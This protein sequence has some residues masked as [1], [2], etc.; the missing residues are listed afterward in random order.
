[1]RTAI[2]TIPLIMASVTSAMDPPEVMWE[3]TYG[4]VFYDVRETSSGDCV[5]A[6]RR[7]SDY[8]RTVFLYSPS[9]ELLWEYS[10]YPASL[11]NYSIL[12]LPEGG[13]VAVGYGTAE[14]GGTPV[15]LS[16]QKISAEGDSV[17]TRLYELPDNCRGCAYAVAPLPD[18]GFAVCGNK[19]PVEGMDQAW[20]LRTDSQGDT[21]WT[22]EW[23]WEYNDSA[24]GVLYLDEGLTVLMQGRLESTTGGPHLVRYDMDGNLLWET[25]IPELAGKHAQDM[26]E[27]SDG[28]LLIL[29]EYGPVV[30]AHTDYFGNVDWMFGPPGGA[31][32]YGQSVSTTMDGG[33]LFGGLSLDI[34]PGEDISDSYTRD[35]PHGMVT[36]HDSLGN[37]LWRDYV[38]NS[39]CIAI[40]SVRQLSQGGYIAAGR[41]A[42]QGFLMR[43]A[44]ELGI[45]DGSF[46]SRVA[47]RSL[48][49]NPSHGTVTVGFSIPGQGEAVIQVFDLTG[50]LVDE[51]AGGVFPAGEHTVTWAPSPGLS[52]GC[53]IVRVASEGVM[54]TAT[55]VLLR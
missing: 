1:M 22:R 32:P 45:E 46:S 3:L 50:R 51:I 33:I 29:T 47:I 43:Y 2:M 10:S 8:A 27:A 16:I 6:G 52:G 28:G 34:P 18:G 31:Q 44:P 25:A 39:G 21:L 20:I 19:D 13:F 23:G 37:E 14:P 11:L 7:W 38:Y 15:S 9:G 55:C 53:Y 41:T 30:I 26:C 17:W 24:L 12:E 36:R 40:Y 5:V 54:D 48:T 35:T 4:S 49:P 42:S